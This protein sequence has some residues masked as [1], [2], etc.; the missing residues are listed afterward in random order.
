MSEKRIESLDLN[1]IVALHWLLTERNVTAASKK[2]GLSQPA[3]SRTLA[4]LREVFG[5]PLLVKSG[6]SMLL[7]RRAERLQPTVAQAVDKCRDIFVTTEAFEPKSVEGQFRI[8]CVDYTS[9]SIMQAWNKHVRPFAPNLD[10]ET[11]NV[12]FEMARDLVSGKVDLVFIP[13]P[14]MLILP[15]GLDLDQFVRKRAIP[16]TYKSAVRKGH[17]AAKGR[18]TLKRF[19]ELEHILVAPEGTRLGV[20][21]RQL[22]GPGLTR[23][24]P[25][26][27]ASFLAALPLIQTTDC[28][29]TAP[30]GLLEQDADRL[31]IF[32]PPVKLSNI[33]LFAG[34]H[35]NWTQ[36]ERHKWVRDKLF[37]GLAESFPG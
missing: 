28:A 12:T 21:D 22:A 24:I 19:A 23:R 11:V 32:E 31:H 10:L 34:W 18:M 30:N 36:D 2:V 25:Y 5:D 8:A 29:I 6:S 33:D 20:V 27:T 14:S 26:M 16:Q 1:L 15:P 3:M 7:T 13:D 9:V 17:P 4:R 35:P 37:E